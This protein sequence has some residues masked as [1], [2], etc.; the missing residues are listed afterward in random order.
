ML[1]FK[2]VELG[3]FDMLTCRD[4]FGKWAT[5]LDEYVAKIYQF[6]SKLILVIN[7]DSLATARLTCGL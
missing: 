2:M 5:D 7:T 3:M 1:Q 6:T 4:L